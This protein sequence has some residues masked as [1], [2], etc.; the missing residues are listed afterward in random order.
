MPKYSLL[1]DHELCWGCKTCEVACKQEFHTPEGVK[2]I[3][4][5]EIGPRRVEDKVDFTFHVN[6]CQH[7]DDAPCADACPDEAIL[8]RKDGIVILD[9]KKC[10]GCQLCIDACPYDAIAIDSAKGIAQKCNLCFHRIDKGLNPACADNIC[11]AHCIN[12]ISA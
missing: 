3:R 4:V 6:V 1:I 11:L 9:E 5:E 10:T 12:L 7:C 2:L 8:K